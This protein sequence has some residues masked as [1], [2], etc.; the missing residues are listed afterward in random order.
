MKD[1]VGQIY[2]VI[3]AGVCI[4]V[5]LVGGLSSGFNFW[6]NFTNDHPEEKKKGI[7][8][9]VVTV[10]ALVMI[11]AV[12]GIIWGVMQGFLNKIPTNGQLS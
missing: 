2:W 6:D 11:L 9:L 5:G 1:A 7:H 4:I 3:V 12:S 8:G 10:V